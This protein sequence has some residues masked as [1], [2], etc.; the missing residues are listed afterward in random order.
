MLWIPGL[1]NVLQGNQSRA[2]FHRNAELH[3]GQQF[4]EGT[5]DTTGS[6]EVLPGTFHQLSWAGEFSFYL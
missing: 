1:S 4:L 6:G 5:E 3:H 2:E